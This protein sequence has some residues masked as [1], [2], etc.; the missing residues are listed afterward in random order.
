MT[1]GICNQPPPS[2]SVILGFARAEP[3]RRTEARSKFTDET[4]AR[5]VVFASTL[6][7]PNQKQVQDLLD[8]LKALLSLFTNIGEQ[9]AGIVSGVMYY[10]G[11]KDGILFTAVG[12]ILVYLVFLLPKRS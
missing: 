12:L 1:H 8:I 4:L 9:L 5:P 7:M 6:D 11:V 2:G 3:K 10:Q